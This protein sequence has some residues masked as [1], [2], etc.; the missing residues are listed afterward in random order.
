MIRVAKQC[1]DDEASWI[2][3]AL[4]FFGTALASTMGLALESHNFAI[5]FSLIGIDAVIRTA[6]HPE[7][8]LWW[9]VGIS[10]FIAYLIRPTFSIFGLYLLCWL[11]GVSRTAA[12]KAAILVL[13]LLSLFVLFSM[14]TYGQVLP[15]YYLPKRLSAGDPTIALVGNLFSP[16]RGLLVFSS[17]IG[18]VWLFQGHSAQRWGRGWL[19]VALLWPLTHLYVISRFPHWWGGHSYGP[20]LMIDCLPGLLLLTLVVWPNKQILKTTPIRSFLLLVSVVFSLFANTGQG[21]FNP[22]TAHWSNAPDIDDYPEYLFDWRYPLFLAN[23]RGH[24]RRA[25]E[26][27]AKYHRNAWPRVP[28]EAEVP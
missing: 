28:R 7:S 4:F 3:P 24:Q 13:L 23:E 14:K 15:D 21:M 2:V 12:L 27:K 26:F 19:F 16:A 25:A 8:E 9:L 5:V 20:R 17:F 10:V 22:Y 1:R 18:I 6:R 11:F